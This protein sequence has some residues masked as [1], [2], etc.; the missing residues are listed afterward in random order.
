[1]LSLWILAKFDS[2]S[3][4]VDAINTVMPVRG[5]GT[6]NYLCRLQNDG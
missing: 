5:F 6:F 1:M 3:L 2:L 4:A